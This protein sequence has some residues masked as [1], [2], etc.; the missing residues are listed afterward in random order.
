[1]RRI[2]NYVVNKSPSFF[3]KKWIRRGVRK[4]Q[5]L[6]EK[7]ARKLIKIVIKDA[8]YLALNCRFDE[9][10]DMVDSDSDGDSKDSDSIRYYYDI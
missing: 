6:A 7:V 10:C 1:M 9:N 3:Q 4:K 5:L 2:Q 8:I